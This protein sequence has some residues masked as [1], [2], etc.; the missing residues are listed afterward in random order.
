MPLTLPPLPPPP[1]ATPFLQKDG[2]VSP[3]W[4]RWLQQAQATLVA[5]VALVP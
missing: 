3:T 2:T 5:L 4:A 1:L